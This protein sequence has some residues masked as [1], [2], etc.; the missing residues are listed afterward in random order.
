MLLPRLTLACD[1]LID[2]PPATAAAPFF[3]VFHL[4]LWK[5]LC[6][7]QYYRPHDYAARTAMTFD[8]VYIA[9][10]YYF[11]FARLYIRHEHIRS[12]YQL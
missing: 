11:A 12:T 1:V 5:F 3:S 7:F 8:N 10:R 4:R 2:T 9:D 6:Q